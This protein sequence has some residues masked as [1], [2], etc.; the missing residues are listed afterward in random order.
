M[1]VPDQT[2]FS[3][4]RGNP[5]RSYNL[6]LMSEMLRPYGNLDLIVFVFLFCFSRDQ[7]FPFPPWLLVTAILTCQNCGFNG[8]TRRMYSHSPH[9]SS[10]LHRYQGGNKSTVFASPQIPP[11][12]WLIVQFIVPLCVL[13]LPTG[14]TFSN[15][16][17][18]TLALLFDKTM[19]HIC[20][21][22][23][24]RCML[25]FRKRKIQKNYSKIAYSRKV[26]SSGSEFQL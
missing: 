6:L 1:P 16:M 10:H 18:I 8:F 21:F 12:L 7:L 5:I 20:H 3:S 22:F 17:M 2:E 15:L 25:R 14:F 4:V 24:R 9:Y 11:K 13:W 23:P 19:H 26:V